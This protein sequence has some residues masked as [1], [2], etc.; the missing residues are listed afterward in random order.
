M[1]DEKKTITIEEAAMVINETLRGWRM[2]IGDEVIDTWADAAQAQRDIHIAS[3]DWYMES[4][5]S[6]A[7]AFHDQWRAWMYDNGWTWGEARDVE[8]KKHPLIVPW[9]DLPPLQQ[10]KTRLCVAVMSIMAPLIEHPESGGHGRRGP[11]W[12]CD[13]GPACGQQF[14]GARIA[15]MSVYQRI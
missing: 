11:G 15:N 6:T 14:N 5:Q 10:I 4:P 2:A 9:D 12:K 13:A 1:S 8:A 7:K 3:I